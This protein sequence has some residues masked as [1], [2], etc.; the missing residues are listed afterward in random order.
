MQS[1]SYTEATPSPKS[2]LFLHAHAHV[3]YVLLSIH[4]TPSSRASCTYLRKH[5]TLFVG[6]DDAALL[7][8]VVE[9]TR[10]VLQSRQ[11]QHLLGILAFHEGESVQFFV[12]G[13]VALDGIQVLP[14]ALEVKLVE[15]A[16]VGGGEA[17]LRVALRVHQGHLLVGRG[18]QVPALLV[19]DSLG[20]VGLA[21][22]GLGIGLAMPYGNPLL[23][24]S[25]HPY[26]RHG[27]TAL[28]VHW[29][30]LGHKKNG[31]SE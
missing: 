4:T 9:Q 26:Y 25:I 28:F 7:S 1:L 17:E 5:E 24:P 30:S 3:E 11:V 15:D 31:S 2:M 23:A 10:G 27:E 13:D 29:R 19:S 16:P 12:R 14:G 8:H 21:F 22:S 18:V 6:E 20:G